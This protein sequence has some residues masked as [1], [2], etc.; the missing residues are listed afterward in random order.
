ME[1][2][3]DGR[4]WKKAELGEAQ[5]VSNTFKGVLGCKKRWR[6]TATHNTPDSQFLCKP[7]FAMLVKASV[8]IPLH[9]LRRVGKKLF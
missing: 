6:T 1:T 2:E 9:P 3:R 4:E 5:S 7:N 8:K